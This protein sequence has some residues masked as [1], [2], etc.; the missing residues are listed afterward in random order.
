MS[1]RPS[2]ALREI[3][4][5]LDRRRKF[6]AVAKGRIVKKSSAAPPI[7]KAAAEAAIRKTSPSSIPRKPAAAAIERA[8]AAMKKKPS[9]PT[10]RASAMKVALQKL[11]TPVP[12][13]RAGTAMKNKLAEAAKKSSA[14]ISRAAPALVTLPADFEPIKEGAAVCVRTPMGTTPS[15]LRLFIWLS[16]VV[17]SDAE[18]G[19]FEVMYKGNFPRDDPSRT[20]RV[21]KDQVKKMPSSSSRR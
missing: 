21:P 6:A 20:V 12:H 9:M 15:G 14:P 7:T 10:P 17:V 19:Y 11:P 3:H 16:A 2:A 5:E 18:D 8:G 13:E 4:R 1:K